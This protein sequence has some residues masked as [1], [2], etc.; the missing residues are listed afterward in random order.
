MNVENNYTAE[1]ESEQTKNGSE[2]ITIQ[3]T[4]GDE[5]ETS[6]KL[7]HCNDVNLTLCLGLA[8]FLGMKCG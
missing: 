1:T 6:I 4:L 2:T 8:N 5:G 3:T 7:K